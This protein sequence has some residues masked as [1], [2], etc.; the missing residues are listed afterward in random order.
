MQYT[1]INQKQV[2]P[3]LLDSENVTELIYN[4]SLR[5][6]DIKDKGHFCSLTLS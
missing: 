5:D 2:I 6:R 1:D 4:I 3:E